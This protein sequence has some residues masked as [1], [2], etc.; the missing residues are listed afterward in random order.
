MACAPPRVLSEFVDS[1]EK[2]DSVICGTVLL[3]RN[4]FFFVSDER[5]E[6][7]ARAD[8]FFFCGGMRG[9]SGPR[10]RMKG[11]CF[12]LRWKMR[13]KVSLWISAAALR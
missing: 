7:F 1:G 4:F 5:Q 12:F 13:E 10:S 3:Y 6:V 2:F 9:C 11:K 8:D